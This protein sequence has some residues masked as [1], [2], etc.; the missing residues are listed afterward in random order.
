MQEGALMLRPFYFNNVK[1]SESWPVGH[2][3]SAPQSNQK[4]VNSGISSRTACN[5][6]DLLGRILFSL[7]ENKMGS[8]NA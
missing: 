4:E 5:S 8:L 6:Y 1:K 3:I 2:N 7:M